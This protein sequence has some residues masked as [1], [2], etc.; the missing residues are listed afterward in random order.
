VCSRGLDPH[1]WRLLS[2]VR[3]E[4]AAGSFDYSR[5]AADITVSRGL[6]SR[7]AAALTLG[8][9]ASGG[10]LP[11]QRWW[12]LGGAHTVRGQSTATRAGDTYW[13]ARGEIGSS[14]VLARP[15][16][17]ADFGWAGDRADFSSPGTPISGVGVGASFLDGLVRFDIAKGIRPSR[18][19]RGYMYLEAR[20]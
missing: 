8:G 6:G 1:G 15:V 3:V 7:A 5:A 2:D 17:F 4:A 19:L 11:V 14:F 20:F 12:F 16:V 13:L 9:G 10:T 18:G